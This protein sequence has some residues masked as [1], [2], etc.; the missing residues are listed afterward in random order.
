MTFNAIKQGIYGL[1]LTNSFGFRLKKTNDPMEKKRLRHAYSAA[2]LEALNITI[3]IKNKEKL[4]M[5]GQ[6]LIVTNH[7]SIIDPPIIEVALT[8]DRNFWSMDFKERA[9]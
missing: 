1:Y 5:D 9:L 2:Q 8:A 6:Y 4:P 3:K 7:R